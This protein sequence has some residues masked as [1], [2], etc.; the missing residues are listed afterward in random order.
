MAVSQDRPLQLL[1]KEVFKEADQREEYAQL[2]TYIE[3]GGSVFPLVKMGVQGL[4]RK[5]HLSP[6]DAQSYLRR[7]NALAIYVR[8]QFIEQ[9]LTGDETE[10]MRPMNGLLSMVD[11]PR[12]EDVFNTNFEAF[13]PPDA[14]ESETSPVAYLIELLMWIKDRIE[15]APG[16][17][18]DNRLRMPLNGRRTDLASLSI[19][20][21]A[22]HQA[23]SSVDIIIR[24]LET[25]IKAHSEGS[26]D[27]DHLMSQARYPNGLPYYR[28][29]TT[30]DF[31]ARH[32]DLSVGEVARVVDLSFPYFLQPNGQSA[33]SGRALL[34]A[35]RL[36]PYQRQLLTEAPIE[37][38]ESEQVNAFY[39]RNFGVGPGVG[40]DPIGNMRWVYFFCERT[41]LDALGLEAL[42]S[43]RSFAPVRS[44]NASAGNDELSTLSSMQSGSVYI[45]ADSDEE[46]IDVEVKPGAGKIF[47]QSLKYASHA[48]YD[49]MNRKL[50]LDQW[51]G[52]PPEQVD[53]LL[54]AAI[55]T[56]TRAQAPEHPCW[57]SP[58]TLRAIGLFQELRERCGCTAEDFAVFIDELSIFGRGETLSQFD[59]VFNPPSFSAEPLTLDG[60]DFPVFPA[61]GDEGLT[62]NRLCRGLGI[63]LH[64]YRHLA[65]AI[66]RA[67]GKGQTLQC[68]VATVS[69]FYRL[70]KLPLLLGITSVE[71][72]DLL[73]TLGGDNWLKVLAGVPRLHSNEQQDTMPDV[74]NVIHAMDECVRWCN[75]HRWSARPVA[76]M[77]Q[78]VAPITVPA[79][80]STDELQL[81]EQL[82]NLLTA[83]L[84]S[85]DAL[86][87]AGVPPTTRGDDWLDFLVALVDRD[88]LVMTQLEEEGEEK[89]TDY[90]AYAR[91]R[92][93]L[94]VRAGIGEE[95]ED[96]RKPIVENML[97][98]LLQARAGQE[99][100]V[101]EC[102]AVYARLQ[103]ERVV[104]VLAWAQ[105]TVYQVLRQAL[106]R[107]VEGDEVAA[108]R[109]REGDEGD[110]F[111]VLLADVR[112]RSAVVVVLDLSAALLED[113]L[114]YGYRDWLK[115]EDKHEFTLSTLYYLTV[116]TRAFNVGTQPPAALLDYLRE[117]NA[118]PDS[119]TG[120][121]SALAQETA[122]IRLAIFFNWSIQ[123]VRECANRIDSQG[124]IKNLVQLDLLIRVRKLAASSGMDAQTIFLMGTVP[125]E[126]NRG[127]Y[128]QA[129]EHALLSLSTSPVPFVP[130]DAEALEQSVKTTCVV[131]RT[132]LVANKA[133]EKATYRVTVKDFSGKGLSGVYVYWQTELGSINK[134][135]T[136]TSGEATAVFTPGTVMGTAA[137]RYWLDLHPKQQA[138]S[139]EIGADTDSMFFPPPLKSQ[140]PD[141]VVPAGQEIEL[142][143]VMQDGHKNLGIGKGVR[144]SSNPVAGVEFS[145]LIIRPSEALTN[146]DGLTRVFASSPSGGTFEI[147]VTSV[148]SNRSVLFDQIIFAG[149]ALPR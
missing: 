94:A 32:H 129:A 75:E 124:L 28:D 57:I 35:S 64:T 39:E 148:D 4:V 96:S 71:A 110:P 33:D 41:K 74:L 92:L 27:L 86:L 9:T 47:Q 116:L 132:E 123:E 125:A 65:E 5:F 97:G 145:G 13:C 24:V 104:W 53:A 121:A 44:A 127:A 128:S 37:V 52:L 73:K 122:A 146:Q 136:N 34:H 15:S 87:M 18:T 30:I 10:L 135:A 51:L 126:V 61:P 103:S 2:N 67:Q 56:E 40:V 98:V 89:K 119:L 76:W 113:Y 147:G 50:R 8:R 48:R 142:F 77:L 118:L 82:R 1:F 60:S 69:S 83:A 101:R 81:F 23:V 16:D 93:H 11:G 22:V 84:F 144:W 43:I 143:A 99:S 102:L 90:P 140:V 149:G 59:R 54:M 17:D 91:K 29:W 108:Y 58:D 42:L 31:V 62:V 7:A 131:D 3:Q 141:G 134:S 46:A 19:D 72:I 139:V 112:R 107:T 137:P 45:N 38:E 111:L 78:V 20:F 117:V 88:G 36:G 85:N 55:N 115:R 138:P 130:Y 25:F 12:F 105:G 66:A 63:K 79:A 68:D 114:A 49:R 95:H 6:G 109:R 80:A 14:L 120:D 133:D 21:K 100:V 106:E 26:D 70:V